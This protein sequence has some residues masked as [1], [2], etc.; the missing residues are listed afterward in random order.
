M[1]IVE[2]TELG[3]RSVVLTL[4]RRASPLTFLLF[5][6]LHVG[7]PEFYATVRER[8][9]GCDLVVVEGVGKSL[10]SR[11]LTM[12]YRVVRLRSGSGLIVQNLKR[13]SFG[14]PFVQGD[15][16]NPDFRQGWRGIPWQQRIMMWC[17]LPLFTLRVLIIGPRR[18]IAR[19]PSV[20]DEP[21]LAL[22]N[23]HAKV[24]DVFDLI[25]DKRDRVLLDTL[26]ELHEQHCQENITVAVVYG[27]GHIAAVVHGLSA[28]YGYTTRAGE[29][30]TVVDL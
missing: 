25:V 17:I 24:P 2:T 7:S 29:F 3:I 16:D 30:I 6:M 1:Q 11:L 8:V 9:T 21:T 28:R 15:M 19:T 12:S 22:L 27:A 26:A 10:A 20:D 13:D 5:P 18:Y 4:G 14:T 23:A